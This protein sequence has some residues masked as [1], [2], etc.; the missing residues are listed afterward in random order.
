MRQGFRLGT[1]VSLAAAGLLAVSPDA[2]ASASPAPVPA[3]WWQ[4]EGNASDTVGAGAHPDNGML[5]RAGFGPGVSGTDQAFSFAGGGQ[6][7]V[8]NKHGGNRQRGDLTLSF[9]IKTTAAT[10]Q[11][12]VWE[13]RIACDTDGTPSR[14][15]RALGACS[16]HCHGL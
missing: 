5:K 14:G 7:V 1:V 15:T 10:V 9:D 12:G 13:K 8:F 2:G 11:Q 4:A 16:A 6:Q 3:H